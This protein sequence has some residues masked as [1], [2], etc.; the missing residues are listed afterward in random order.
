MKFDLGC[1]LECNSK[2]NQHLLGT[3]EMLGNSPYPPGQLPE[4]SPDCGT[5]GTP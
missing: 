1:N 5:G 4:I 3:V 2:T